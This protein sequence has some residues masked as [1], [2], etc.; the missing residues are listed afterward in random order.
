MGGLGMEKLWYTSQNM[1][2]HPIKP[3]YL[4]VSS[5]NHGLVHGS[6]HAFSYAELAE[7]LGLNY[8]AYYLDQPG[9]RNTAVS[10]FA[11]RLQSSKHECKVVHEPVKYVSSFH[12]AHNTV[13][14]DHGRA[15]LSFAGLALV[16]GAILAFMFIRRSRTNC[17]NYD[18]L[19]QSKDPVADSESGLSEIE[20]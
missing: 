20:A 7:D 16:S 19:H 1:R 6:M 14:Y 17:P 3:F 8:T 4:H 5:E 2:A 12:C 11:A 18:A 13:V 15:S 9:R 10:A